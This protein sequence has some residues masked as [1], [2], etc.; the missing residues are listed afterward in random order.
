MRVSATAYCSHGVTGSGERT[1]RGSVAA[2]PHLI[3]LGSTIRVQGLQGVPDGTYTVLD[4]GRGIRG[5]EIDVFIPRCGAARQFGRQ[6][7]RVTIIQRGPSSK[8]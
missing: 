7:V 3:P 5:R 6:N 8:S 4:T 2:D 1:R